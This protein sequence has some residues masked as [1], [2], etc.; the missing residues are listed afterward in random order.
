MSVYN[1]IFSDRKQL[2]FLI[3]PENSTHETVKN[4]VENANQAGV[5]CI[6]VG[7]SLVAGRVD[8]TISMVKEF[9][10]KPVVLFPGSLLQ[11]SAKADAILFLNL[12]SGRNPE[13]L[14]GNQVIA[15]PFIRKHNMECIPTAYMLI[16]SGR[17]TA[18]EYMSGTKPLPANKADIIVAT[19][20]ASEL[21]GHKAIYL[22]A[23]SGALNPISSEIINKVSDSVSIPIIVGGGLRSSESIERVFNAGGNLAV[24]GNA[25]QES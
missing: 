6:L 4:T 21:M 25:L 10:D 16:E 22:E 11:L 17:T 13:Y 5:G 12:V 15:A 14:I 20:M 3:D 8:E 7:G 2:A 24:V 9:T 1:K 23:G 18:V 19:A